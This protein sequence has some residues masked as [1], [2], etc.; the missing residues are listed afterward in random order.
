MQGAMNTKIVYSEK[1]LGYGTWHIEGPQRVKITHDVLA[2]KGYEFV[3]PIAATEEQ[4]LSVHDMEYVFNL[5]KGL[6]EDSDTP[7]YDKIFDF[8][9]LSAGAALLA[10]QIGGFS[11]T[12]PPGHHV[13]KYGSALGVYTRGFCY[14]NNIAIAVKDSGKKTLILD[15]DGHHGNGTQE[16]FLGDETV[17][18]VSVHQSP[19]YPGTGKITEANC[20]NFALPPNAGGKVYQ[21]TLDAALKCVNAKEFEALAVSAGFDTHNCDL[22]SLGLVTK[23]YFEIGK[24]IAKLNLPTFFVLEG[25]YNGQNVGSDIDSL[26]RGYEENR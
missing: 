23:D 2:T 7:A 20:I 11:I 13:G 19:N 24:K 3:E 21:E 12:R 22:A 25:G 17:T 16:I 1:C 8:A 6:V 26:L 15:I 14:L 5:K 4:V 10:S 9:Q 18:Y